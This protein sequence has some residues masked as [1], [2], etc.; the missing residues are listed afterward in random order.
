MKTIFPYFTTNADQVG[1]IPIKNNSDLAAI[2]NLIIKD[3]VTGNVIK[4]FSISLIANSGMICTRQN[5]LAGL[6]DKHMSL[7]L[8][9]SESITMHPFMTLRTELP[10]QN[11]VNLL[12]TKVV[13]INSTANFKFV[14]SQN[15][16]YIKS[17]ILSALNSVCESVIR[18][19]PGTKPFL[20]GNACPITGACPENSSHC[21]HSEIDI[22]YPTYS[23]K[24]TQYGGMERI[25]LNNDPNNMLLDESK[26][27]WK[28]L[29]QFIIRLKH[30]C[31][32]PQHETQIIVHEKI[33]AVISSKLSYNDSVV[34]N[35]IVTQDIGVHLNHH[36]HMHLK[37]TLK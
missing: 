25:W 28:A 8:I 13:A 37:L 17:N 11:A 30:L 23:G 36:T 16:S 26:V 29:Y 34:L 5:Y 18:D 27:N 12:D 1:V 3:F 33:I 15:C 31:T 14:G 20:F 22:D 9:G 2:S 4:S 6:D 32:V 21:T 24:G 10:I 19:V 7:E 35:G